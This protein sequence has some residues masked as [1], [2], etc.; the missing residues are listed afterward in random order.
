LCHR[1]GWVCGSTASHWA[2]DHALS[3]GLIAQRFA[4]PTPGQLEQYC[5]AGVYLKNQA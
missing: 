1:H 4:W 5:D 3:T 2:V